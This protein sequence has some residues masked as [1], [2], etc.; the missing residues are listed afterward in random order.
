MTANKLRRS[1]DMI[2]RG[3]SMARPMLSDADYDKA[4]KVLAL[5]ADIEDDLRKCEECGLECS[6]RNERCQFI[7]TLVTKIKSTFFPNRA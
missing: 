2:N 5:L 6:E 4:N 1:A 7:R 3:M